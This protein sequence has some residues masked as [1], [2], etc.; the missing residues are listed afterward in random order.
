MTLIPNTNTVVSYAYTVM[1][2]N[3]KIGT[4]QGFNPSANRALE[5]IREL[6]NE[7][8][9]IKEITPGRTDFDITIER[10]E[11]Y[12][13]AMLDALGYASF[14]DLSQITDPMNIVEEIRGPVAKGS[15]RRTIVYER[16]WITSWAK[17]IREGTITVT[18]TVSLWPERIYRQ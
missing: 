1:V 6:M 13:E 7:V 16:C 8:D 18:E 3:R 14:E 2:G 9:D 5:R 11:T 17:Q 15:P 12:D 10:L 4:L